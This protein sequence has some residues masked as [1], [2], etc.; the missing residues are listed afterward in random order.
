MQV[1]EFFCVGHDEVT[2]PELAHFFFGEWNSN[3]SKG[4]KTILETTEPCQHLRCGN[5]NRHDR[6]LLQPARR[7][8]WR[9]QFP[10][11]DKVPRFKDPGRQV[12]FPSQSS[13]SLPVRDSVR[14]L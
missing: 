1:I 3:S 6:W 13:R 9:T 12:F 5:W 8:M 11:K 2:G 7:L 4:P 14:R 10:R